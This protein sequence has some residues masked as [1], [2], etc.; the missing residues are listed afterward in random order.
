MQIASSS[1]F[2]TRKL[3]LFDPAIAMNFF[4]N[5]TE[6]FPSL[7]CPSDLI[8]SLFYVCY[9]I[10]WLRFVPVLYYERDYKRL[11]RIANE[12]SSFSDNSI[13]MTA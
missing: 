8:S 5:K 6:V 7:E 4:N 12:S 2:D 13:I 3:R 1:M 11:K 10:I 9:L